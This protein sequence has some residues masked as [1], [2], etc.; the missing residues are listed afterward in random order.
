MTAGAVSEW[1]R[2]LH[3][4]NR[5]TR[6]DPAV[7]TFADV[8]Q[9]SRRDIRSFDR[10]ARILV[11]DFHRAGWRSYLSA[12]GHAIMLAPDGK[13]TAA[14]S[15]H[16][17]GPHLR[18]MARAD[19]NRWLKE[20]RNPTKNDHENESANVTVTEPLPANGIT[21]TT[22]QAAVPA[23]FT[24]PDCPGRRFSSGGALA[25]HRQRSH[26]GLKCPDCGMTFP[27]VGGSAAAYKQ[28][29]REMHGVPDKIHYAPG[30]DGNYRCPWCPKTYPGAGAL[31]THASRTHGG[32]PLP[33]TA[34][35]VKVAATPAPA[36]PVQPAPPLVAVVEPEPVAAEPEVIRAAPQREP[37]P[38]AALAEPHP[39]ADL[40]AWLAGRDPADLL[41]QAMAVLAPPLLGQLERLRRQN[42]D[43]TA[44][45]EHL[46]N[47]LAN[48][49]ARMALVRE[50]AAMEV[51]G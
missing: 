36:A 25:L 32:Q 23:P 12:Q 48:H 26:D 24:C 38:A 15:G 37:E 46:R 30:P 11:A 29:R 1:R 13:T 18:K 9:V 51:E 40:D 21:T 34:P 35:A 39:A 19:L 2:P 33:L 28:H 10:E 50:A 8:G 17:K 42:A 16:S 45:V 5:T 27:P 7:P 22:Q 44:E 41:T 4:A 31:A 49:D 3:V 47:R 14:V 6:R 20:Q 43:L